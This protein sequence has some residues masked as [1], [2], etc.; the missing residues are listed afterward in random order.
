MRIKPEQLKKE[1]K[2]SLYPL[3]L[4]TGDEPL[5]SIESADLIRSAARRQDYTE[6]QVFHVERGFD[7]EQLLQEAN[8]LS[9]FATKKILELRLN[10][11]K[12]GDSGSKALVEYC[13]RVS[14]DNILIISMPKLDKRAQNL[15]WFKR[16]E[17]I[18]V[19]VQI[20]PI[21]RNH[22]SQ[23]IIRRARDRGFSIDQEA[24]SLLAEKVEGNLLAASQEIDK[25]SLVES[26]KVSLVDVLESSS[27]DAKYDVYKLVDAALAGKHKRFARILFGLEAGGEVPSLVLWALTREIR[28]ITGISWGLKQGE[29]LSKL[30]HQ[31]RVWDNRAGLVSL[32]LKRYN[33]EQWLSLL[34]RAIVLDQTI[35]GLR[36][37]N[38]WDDL[39]SLGFSM[40]GKELLGNKI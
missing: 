32:G 37:G 10:T 34:S 26:T 40:S 2:N 5:Q 9:L 17:A 6:R 22:L 3:Y 11:S 14:A 36:K 29:P 12:I 4:I 16:L 1:L 33:T 27:N 8:S 18:G 35:K 15:K 31:H 28:L 23:W 30:L 39:L 13:D 24:A 20:W 38:I 21:E 25:L 7:W 19:V